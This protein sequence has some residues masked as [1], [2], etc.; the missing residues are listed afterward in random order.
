M[1]TIEDVLREREKIASNVARFLKNKWDE[2]QGTGRE[3]EVIGKIGEFLD[4]LGKKD[5][6]K[7]R[8][9]F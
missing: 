4:A 1:E 7:L 3:E 2:A 5:Y 8:E 6:K 9:I